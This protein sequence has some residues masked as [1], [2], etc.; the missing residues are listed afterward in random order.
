M[1]LPAETRYSTMEPGA[2]AILRCL[3]EVRWLILG[4]P[5]PTKV[6]PDHQALVIL[7]RKDDAHGRIVRWQ[8]RLAEYDVEYIHIPGK[9]ERFGKWF[10]QNEK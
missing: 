5:F 6:Y 8:I 9:R 3:E 1:A 10:E 7:L 2:L 4:S